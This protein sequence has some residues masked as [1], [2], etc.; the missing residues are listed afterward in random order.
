M[1]HQTAG[2]NLSAPQK[3]QPNWLGITKGAVLVLLTLACLIGA[4]SM[5][6][7]SYAAGPTPSPRE[8]LYKDVIMLILSL[9][10]SVIIGYWFAR[11]SNL[12]K[13]DT[14][15]ER[16]T[17]KMVLL[18]LQLDDLRTYLEDTEQIALS[19]LPRG[20]TAGALNAYRHRTQAAA[21]L[22]ST[23]ANSNET[24]RGDWLGVVSARMRQEI[25]QKYENLRRYFEANHTLRGRS[26]GGEQGHTNSRENAPDTVAQE[27]LEAQQ[28][29]EQIRKDLPITVHTSPPVGQVQA[30]AVK[31][32]TGNLLTNKSQEGEITLT[33]IRDAFMITGT[34]KLTPKMI[35][36]PYIK[37]D[38]VSSPEPYTRERW[39]YTVGV[40]TNFD[41]NIKLKSNMYGT[42]LATGDYKFRYLATAQAPHDDFGESGDRGNG[43]GVFSNPDMS[44]NEG[45]L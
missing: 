29:I 36:K 33:V 16:S 42:P 31:Q 19:E 10:A 20:T 24:F 43:G 11:F 37:L 2:L 35:S 21:H 38:L 30:V 32:E 12:E 4:L 39:H 9:I 1:D 26:S 5:I 13:V 3:P 34:G 15:A 45:V 14:I 17:E 40:G 7:L 25:E 23:L 22:I 27:I 8:G 28:T 6:W 41:F 44:L 18:S